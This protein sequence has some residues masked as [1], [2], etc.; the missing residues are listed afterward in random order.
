MK[1]QLIDAAFKGANAIHR[2]LFEATDG[3]VGKTLFGMPVLVLETVGRKSGQRRKSM[4][5]AALQRDGDIVLVASKGGDDRHPAWYHNLVANPDVRITMG[6]RTFDATARIASP[7]EK[8]ELWPQIITEGY[9]GYDDYQRRT[10][11][12]IPV[13]VCTPK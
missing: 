6:G 11:R 3:R 5:T 7:D 8:A 2:R 4:L 1:E 13:I 12:D 9:K 10:N